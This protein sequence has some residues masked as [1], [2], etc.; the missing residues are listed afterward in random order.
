MSE[1]KPV[2]GYDVIKSKDKQWWG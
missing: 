1:A 2:L